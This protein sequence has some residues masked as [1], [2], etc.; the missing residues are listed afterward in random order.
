MI[1]G[2]PFWAPTPDASVEHAL[3]L[4]GVK[5]GDHLIDLGC[6]DGRV[7]E[8]AVRRGATAAGY[9]ADPLRA[10]MARQRLA[11][12]NGA[13][14]VEVADFHTAPLE[15][16]VVFAFLSPATLF[17]LR[18]RLAALP[19]RTRIVTYGYGVIGWAVDEL[20][21]N[22][23]L[24]TLPPR[25][26]DSG[27][28]ENWK[29]PALVVSGPPQR[30]VLAALPF[31][32]HAGEIDLEL[33]PTLEP[34]AEVYLGAATCDADCN[35]PV[36]IRITTGDA[37]SMHAG[38]VRV[39]DRALLLVVVAAGEAMKRRQVGSAGLQDLRQAL[40]EVR[41]GRRDAASL[42]SDSAEGDGDAALP[43]HEAPLA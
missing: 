9:E 10:A 11:P 4:A 43:Y 23:F 33:S 30:T 13:A 39:Q 1:D 41:A 3:D 20:S 19:P 25:P 16:D 42:L 5:R 27:S 21:D 8:A 26:S 35:V 15:A 14:R 7:L 18:H 28:I 24:Y 22:C 12:L 17:R 37:G 29:H 32:A 36:D 31:G 6:G 34:V 2:W 38:D 40:D